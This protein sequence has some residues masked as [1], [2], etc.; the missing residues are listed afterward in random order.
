MR[1]PVHATLGGSLLVLAVCR[2]ASAQLPERVLCDRLATRSTRESVRPQA[3]RLIAAGGAPASFVQGCLVWDEEKSDA[4]IKLF[5]AAAAAAPSNS[6][7]QLWLGNAYGVK[8][9]R[10][11]PLSQAM[12]ARKTKAAFDRAVQLDPDN[13]QARD[14]LMQYYLQAPGFV[15]GSVEKASEQAQAIRQRDRYLGGFAV[16][17][18]ANK[19]KDLAGVE[20]ELQALRAAYPD[21]IAVVTSLV[22]L[23]GQQS[24]WRDLW[25]VLDGAE[26]GRLASHPRLP[27]LIGRAAALSGEQLPRGEVALLR[28]IG[29]PPAPGEPRTSSAQF[30]LGQVYEKQGKLEPARTAYRAALALDPKNADATRALKALPSR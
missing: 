2:T 25:T 24:R 18:V 28:Y 23:Y 26:Q 7:Y 3:D 22:A 14:G 12:L 30:R 29:T 21:S 8:A 15:G 20:R 13:L 10:A 5:E 19:R 1:L 17:S 9:Q 4:S 11:N 27:F 16:I 6:D